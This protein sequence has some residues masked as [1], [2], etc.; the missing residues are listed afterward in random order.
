MQEN[1]RVL[2]PDRNEQPNQPDTRQIWQTA[3]RSLRSQV[4]RSDYDYW[5]KNLALIRIEQGVALIAAPSS[6]ARR[7]LETQYQKVVQQA[8]AGVL[9]TQ[10]TVQFTT[11]Q[12]ASHN[13]IASKQPDFAPAQV[14]VGAGG[15]NGGK[16]GADF[17]NSQGNSYNRNG[18]QAGWNNSGYNGTYSNAVA[19][20]THAGYPVSRPNPNAPGN[21]DDENYI[22]DSNPEYDYTGE[23]PEIEEEEVTNN[24]GRPSGGIYPESRPNYDPIQPRTGNLNPKYIFDK[25]IVGNSNRVT[26]SAAK[27]VADNPG[28][29]YNPLFIYGGVGLGKTHLLHAI[30]HEAVRQRPNLTT[31]YVTSE[32]FTNDMV[33][34]IRFRRQ[35]DFRNRYRNIDIL[36]IDDIQFIANKDATQEEF[37]HT[38][39]ALHSDNKQI[40]IC[41]DRPPKAMLILEDRLRS[42]FEGG[43]ITDVQLPDY[44]MR[45]AIL[46]AKA[47]YLATNIPPEVLEYIA[48]KIKSNTRELEGALNRV[49]GYALHSRFALTMEIATQALEEIMSNS[50]RKIV[51]PE[52]VIETVSQ[53]FNID[54][55]E[56]KGR[57][58]SQ[59]IVLPRQIAM[60]IIR[61]HTDISLVEVGQAFGGRDHTTVMHGYDK[62]QREIETNAQLRQQVNTITQILY[63]ESRS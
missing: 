3:L 40:V 21:Y 5:L 49:V 48:H 41:S 15:S 46:Q 27:S 55:K 63:S 32:K 14:P 44:E 47:E 33:E 39:N 30:G 31:L 7:R 17:N 25:F 38:F 11:D 36:L 6:A 51:T 60:Y 52:R 24:Y 35:E 53:F 50:Q 23:S 37:F 56:L 42:R 12:P 4:E 43:F 13:W 18:Q 58:R 59:D 26:Y 16:A 61:E 28:F 45:L 34:A 20:I 57:S 9:G 8:L 29:H 10:L 22:R 62:I 54:A 1:E 19:P 2:R